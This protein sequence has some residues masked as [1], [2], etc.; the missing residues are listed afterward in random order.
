MSELE[1]R[2]TAVL[3]ALKTAT[4]V[5]Q[6]SDVVLLRFECPADTSEAVRQK[7]AS[8]G[9]GYYQKFA[10]K[11]IED[12]KDLVNQPPYLRSVKATL[13]NVREAPGT[14]NPILK[15]LQKGTACTVLEEKDGWGRISAGGWVSL[16][17]LE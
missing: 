2:F 9:D 10:N 7:R 5:R 6:A 1:T 8:Y 16:D 13:L 3:Q 11:K 15:Q 4:S 17:Y 12:I 14:N